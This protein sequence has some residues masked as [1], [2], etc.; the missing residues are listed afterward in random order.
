MTPNLTALLKEID[1]AKSRIADCL[2]LP[3]YTASSVREKFNLDWI[4]HSNALA[5]NSL[6]VIETKVVLEGITIGGKTIAEHLEVVHHCKAIRYVENRLAQNLALDLQAILDLHNILQTGHTND[7]A[8]DG[9][10]TNAAASTNP[11]EKIHDLLAQR[12][13][14]SASHPL[15]Q[16]AQW[17]G[18]FLS[19]SP[20]PGD[21]GRLA[22]LLLNYDLSRAGYPTAVILR[23]EKQQYDAALKQAAAPHSRQ[24][25]PSTKLA[26]NTSQASP[27]DDL[28]I[29]IAQATLRTLRMILYLLGPCAPAPS[30][31]EP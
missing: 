15:I 17:H 22:R 26:Q 30:S 18:L 28:A 1:C 2:P 3:R 20:F 12:C 8:S 16:A 7:P 31:S 27:Y 5:G 6:T 11:V 23:D 19:Q 4:C 24:S 25:A 21:N 9:P 10:S 14:L 13:A 29:L